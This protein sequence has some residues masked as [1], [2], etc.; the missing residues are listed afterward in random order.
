MRHST[1]AAVGG[2]RN[3]NLSFPG[4]EIEILKYYM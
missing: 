2:E 3:N 1:R 4:D